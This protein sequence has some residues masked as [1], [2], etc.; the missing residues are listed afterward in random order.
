MANSALLTPA[1][2]APLEGLL[3]LG[4][5]TRLRNMALTAY[6]HLLEEMRPVGDDVHRVAWLAFTT[7]ESLSLAHGGEQFYMVKGMTYRA[8]QR[9]RQIAAE[10]TGHNIEQLARRY[11]LSEPRVRQIIADYYSEYRSVTQP[12]LDLGDDA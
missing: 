2:R 10:Y 1:Q 12:R 3:P 6:A 8:Q 5:P 7:V 4:Y 11:R 9:A